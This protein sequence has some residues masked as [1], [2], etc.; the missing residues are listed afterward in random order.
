MLTKNKV[1]EIRFLS[2][3]KYRQKSSRGGRR[4]VDRSPQREG[5]SANLPQRPVRGAPQSEGGQVPKQKSLQLPS[6]R[7]KQR[8]QPEERIVLEFF[9]KRAR[10]GSVFQRRWAR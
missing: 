4:R 9:E 7:Q 3:K 8:Q 10:E 2:Q 1:K 6:P 5:N